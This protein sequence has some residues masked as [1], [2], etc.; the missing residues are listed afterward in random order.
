MD[1]EKIQAVEQASY[2]E[3]I[4]TIGRALNEGCNKAIQAV[5]FALVNTNL[6]DRT[7]YR[8]I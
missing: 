3:L 4:E 8:I 7:L 1:N 2:K 5:N 6:A